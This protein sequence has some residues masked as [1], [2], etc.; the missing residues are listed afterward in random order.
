[1]GAAVGKGI[2]VAVVETMR[3][4][5]DLGNLGRYFTPAKDGAS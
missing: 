2:T 1:M 4:P 3:G 5:V